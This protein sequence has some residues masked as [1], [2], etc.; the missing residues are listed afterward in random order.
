MPF[1]YLAWC[2]NKF[3]FIVKPTEGLQEQGGNTI[4]WKK[5]AFRH[6]YTDALRTINLSGQA[7]SMITLRYMDLVDEFE[8]S[9]Q[10]VTKFYNTLRV[11]V[12]VGSLLIPTLVT[13]E[14]IEN[15]KG[16]LFFIILGVSLTVSI[17]NGVIETFSLVRRHHTNLSTSESLQME[18]WS[19]ATL[20]GRYFKYENH[21]DCWR[22]FVNNVEHI[23]AN[24]INKYMISSSNPRDNSNPRKP[25][26]SSNLEDDFI[27]TPPILRHEDDYEADNHKNR[28]WAIPN[29]ISTDNENDT[30]EISTSD[31]VIQVD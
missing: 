9:N 21:E 12:T 13:I 10:S 26:G 7:K 20:C 18:G 24:A 27:Y 14:D 15:E 4:E 19:F 16:P 25:T 31:T 8:K 3:K 22:K 5:R 11:L 29:V 2:L 23:H 17:S 28:G 1:R 6:N 30:S